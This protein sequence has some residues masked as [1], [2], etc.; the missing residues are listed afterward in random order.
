MTAEQRRQEEERVE[1]WEA[2]VTI[3]LPPPQ[4]P[5]PAPTLPS[6]PPSSEGTSRR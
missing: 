2:L 6:A 4:S 1:E 5:R 3:H